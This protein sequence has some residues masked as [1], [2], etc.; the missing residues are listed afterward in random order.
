MKKYFLIILGLCYFGIFWMLNELPDGKIHVD[1]LD[2]GQGDAV[3]IKSSYGHNVLIDGGPRSDVLVELNRRIPFF[4]KEIDLMVL[5]H[6]HS[7]HLDGLIKVLERYKVENVLITGVEYK[8]SYYKEFLKDIAE[9]AGQN[10][11]KIHFAEANFDFV[12]GDIYFDTIY[13]IKSIVGKNFKNINNSSIGFLIKFSDKN[14]EIHRVLLNGDNERG[15][16]E[17]IIKNYSDNYA[18]IEIF[19]ASHH[20]SKTANTIGFLEKFRPKNVVISCG[21]GNG[22]GHPHQE[23]LLNFQKIGATV[24]RTDLSGTVQ[25]EW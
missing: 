15:T 23:S 17:E 18:D 16:E 5:T 1:F 10:S 21:E 14:A 4:M 2:V 6:P 8:N 7:D 13:P 9:K 25:F 24:F 22:F 11:L 20:A 12:V 3:F 19:K